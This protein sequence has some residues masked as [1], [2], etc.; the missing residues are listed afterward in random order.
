MY[1]GPIHILLYIINIIPNPQPN[2]W[3]FIMLYLLDKIL[4]NTKHLFLFILF[5][6]R[7]DTELYN[8]YNFSFNAL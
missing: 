7:G 1:T 5:F 4:Y 2:V 8:T 6:L 3:Y